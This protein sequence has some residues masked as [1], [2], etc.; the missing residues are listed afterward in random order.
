M[1]DENP[2]MEE[3]KQSEDMSFKQG[4]DNNEL[5]PFTSGNNSGSSANSAMISQNKLNFESS[6][7]MPGGMPKFGAPGDV[8]KDA[9]QNDGHSGIVHK[10]N[11]NM[12]GHQNNR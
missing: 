7:Q 6:D 2:R 3:D 12:N 9:R 5:N 10:S 8:Q 4:K 11:G 1:K